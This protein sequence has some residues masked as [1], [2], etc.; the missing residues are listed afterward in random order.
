MNFSYALIYFICTDWYTLTERNSFVCE[1][2]AYIVILFYFLN[3]CDINQNLVD[4]IRIN[5]NE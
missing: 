1:Q 2:N 4:G 3:L 5:K